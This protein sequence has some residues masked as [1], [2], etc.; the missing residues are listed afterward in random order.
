MLIA[1]M[2]TSVPWFWT[3]RKTDDEVAKHLQAS[4]HS[5]HEIIQ[6]RLHFIYAS[7][8]W[9]WQGPIPE[10]YHEKGPI[11]HSAHYC[12]MMWELM[13][14]IRNRWS[15]LMLKA[16]YRCMTMPIH[17]LP[18]NLLKPTWCVGTHSVQQCLPSDQYILV[19]RNTMRDHQFASEQKVKELVHI[20]HVGQ[21][22]PF[23]VRLYNTE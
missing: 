2:N 19:H 11:I 17:I 10:H 20:W 5:T 16:F 14:A 22:T 21:L 3:A 7:C 12:M 8:F 4:H 23:T 6:N 15:T 18:S 9:Y 1:T 13:V